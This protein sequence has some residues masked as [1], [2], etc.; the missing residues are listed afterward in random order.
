M[1]H[2]GGRQ[3][4]F[5]VCAYWNPKALSQGARSAYGVMPL[6]GVC[7]AGGEAAVTAALIHNITNIYPIFTW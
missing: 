1:R 3:A 7:P 4:A 5:L 2:R 6:H